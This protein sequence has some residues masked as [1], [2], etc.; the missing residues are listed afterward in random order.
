MVENIFNKLCIEI[1][2]SEFSLAHEEEIKQKVKHPSL[3]K[4]MLTFLKDEKQQLKREC[5]W[6]TYSALFPLCDKLIE[7]VEQKNKRG[8]ETLDYTIWHNDRIIV[9]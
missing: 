6:Q 8:R 4:S 5:L 3:I 2:N 1:L 7:R 9:K